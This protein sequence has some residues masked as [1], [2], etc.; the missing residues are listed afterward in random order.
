MEF[1]ETG[2]RCAVKVCKQLDFL[3]ITC[4][5]CKETFCKEHFHVN[6]HSCPSFVDNVKEVVAKT[7]SS[8]HNCT[9]DD[10]KDM[11]PL[12]I[13]CVKCGRHYCVAHRFEHYCY[14]ENVVEKAKEMAKWNKPKQD[15]EEAKKNV[16]RNVNEKLKKSKN[17]NLANKVRRKKKRKEYIFN[18]VE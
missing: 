1:P 16:E 13:N 8:Y 11:S 2:V 7:E 12:E 18:N 3:P 6:S 14:K 4:N 5:H 15:F 10:C 9:K 17:A